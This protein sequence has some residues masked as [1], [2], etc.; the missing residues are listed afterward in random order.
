[1]RKAEFFEA[2]A[3]TSSRNPGTTVKPTG[4]PEAALHPAGQ[5]HGFEGI[6]ED[7]EDGNNS[8]YGANNMHKE[9]GKKFSASSGSGIS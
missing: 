9:I 5:Y 4:E 8:G 2:S 7:A 3:V 1:M 6:E